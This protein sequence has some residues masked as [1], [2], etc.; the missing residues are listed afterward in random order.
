MSPGM[1]PRDAQDLVER[2][3]ALARP[4]PKCGAAPGEPCVIHAP[5]FFSAGNDRRDPRAWPH[6]TR[7]N[8]PPAGGDQ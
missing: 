5:S 8:E 2:D 1:N 6:L 4:C 7:Y 3:A